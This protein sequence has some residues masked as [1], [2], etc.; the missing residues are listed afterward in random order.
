MNV[1]AAIGRV[2]LFSALSIGAQDELSAVAV[3]R[4]YEDGQVIMLEGDADTPVFFVV[5]GTVRVYR[6]NLDGREQNLIHLH[7]GDAFFHPIFA[8]HPDWPNVADSLPE[9]A[10]A[11][12]KQLVARAAKARALVLSSHIP[13]PGIGKIEPANGGYRWVP[14]S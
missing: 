2:R 7:T 10:V 6:T 14:I 8:E 11:S 1:P 3:A 13:F 4:R 12:R 9:Q 5:Q